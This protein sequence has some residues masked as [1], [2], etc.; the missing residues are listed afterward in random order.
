ML[1]Q[2]LVV[3]I[4]KYPG[5]QN[6]KTPAG[7]AEMIASL[8]Q[9]H[10]GFQVVKRL[11]VKDN[12]GL[13]SVDE[14]PS[15]QQLVTATTL[16]EAIA[17]LFN[18][19]GNDVPDTALLYFAGHGLRNNK[20]ITEGFLATSNAN[21]RKDVWGVSLN[22]LQRI[23]KS[24]PVKEQIIWL[25]CCYGGELL[26]GQ[27]LN[28]DEANPGEPGKGRDR[29]FIA[30]CGDTSVAYGNAEHGILTSL[31]LKGLDPQRY[32][33][34][35][36]INN[37]SLTDFIIQ[38]LE[39]D[40][41]LRTFPQ[42]PS[43]N[44][45]GG[46]IKLI[47]G[48]AKP[49]EE[50]TIGNTSKQ[51]LQ[52]LLHWLIRLLEDDAIESI[53][54][55]S[56]AIPGKNL[57]VAANNI[58]VFYKDGHSSFIQTQDTENWE[59]QNQIDLE[60]LVPNSKLAMLVLERYIQNNNHNTYLK[61]TKYKITRS[62]ILAELAKHELN[63]TPKRSEAEILANFN[64]AS[65]I[66]RYWLREIDGKKISRS[67][68]PQIIE[69][70]EQ[71]S[72]TILLIDR[73]GSGK[74]CMLLDL[75]DY[76]E[77]KK[78][79][80]W[81]LLFIKGDKFTNI[82]SEQKLT[83]HGLPE[84][85]V[86]QCAR[87][88]DYRKVVVII[89]SLDVLSL[90]RQHGSLKV[91]L[92]IIDRLEKLEKV[93]VIVA[94]RNFDLEYDPL[95]RGRS[96][97]H[98]INLQPLDFDTQVQSFLIDWQVDVSKMTLVLRS[99]LQIPQNLRIYERLA[100]LGVSSQPASAYELY[101]SFLEEVVVKNSILGT[102]AIDA[103]QNMA[104]Q[105]MQQR[106][107]SY[108]KVS[109]GASEDTVR[110]LISQEVLL[111]TSP[112]ILEFSHKTLADCL[113]VRATR[114]KNQTLVQFILQHP[115]LPFIRPAVRA[116]F[117]YLRAYQPDAFRRQVWEVLSHDEIAYHVK[118][119]VSESFAEIEPIEE[120][121]RSLRRIFQNYP[122]L[123]R[124]LLWRANN[125]TW[126]NI[127]TQHWLPEAKLAQ[128]RET[129]LLQFVH[130]LGA[131]MNKYPAE[132]VAFWRQAIAEQ[133]ANPQ[134][135]TGSIRSML[136]SFEAWDTPGIQELLET[137]VEDFEIEE[138]DRLGRL[139]SRW[140]Q[141]TNSGDILLWKYITKNVLPEDVGNWD[142]RNK[143]YC[144]PHEFHQ[145]NFLAERLKQS[146]L[147]LTLAL[148][149][150][151]GWRELLSLT[152]WGLQHSQGVIHSVDS[153]RFL[154]H[155]LE[156]ALKFR[157]RK[158]D[159]WW[160]TNE[161]RLRTLEID[162]IRYFVTQV[163]KENIEANIP[164]IENLL[165]DE[166]LFRWS[167][168]NYELGELMNMAYPYI[169]E[170][171]RV[172]NQTIIWSLCS[173]RKKYEEE[174]SC[175][176]YRR[177]YNFF[178]WIPCIFRT[179]ETQAFIDT[180]QNCFGYSRPEPNIHNWGG[181]VMPP[182]SSQD[183]LKLSNKG[184]FQLLDYY[185]AHKNRNIF[186]RDMIGGFSEVKVVLR[187]ACS[188]HPEKFIRLFISF[189]QENLYQD[190]VCALVE[191]IAFHL[192]YRFG[193]LQPAQQW[194]PIEPLLEGEAIASTLLNW[195]ER[196]FIIWEDGQTVRYALEACC[197]VLTDS[198]SAKRLSLL[199]FW[200]YNKYSEDRKIRINSHDLL[201]TAINSIHG[202]A[203]ESAIKLCNRLLEK[204]QPVP[205][206]LLLLLHHAA[207]DAA[208]YV[209]IPILQH[210]PFLIHKNPDL[211][212]QL[213]ADVFKEPQPHLWK[214]TELCFYYQYHHNFD[215][216]APYLNRLLYEGM[217]EAGDIWGRLSA[218]A[219]LA[220][221]ISQEQLFATLV[222]TNSNAAW[223][224]VTQV[225]IANLELK[226]HRENCITGLINVLGYKN[227]SQDILGK[228]DRC[229][230]EESKR[231]C[232]RREFAVAFLE[233]LPASAR[234]ID[235]DGFLEW[236]GYESRRNPLSALELT[237]TLA[238]KFESRMNV[239]LLWRTEPLI[240]ALNE[241]L[242]EA[243][244][245]D[246]PKLIQRAIN[247]QD[248]FLKLDMRGMEELLNKAGQD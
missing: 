155:S 231:A 17:E 142:F 3:G 186:D 208:I 36:W 165:Q 48:K 82:S 128:E 183:L 198:E 184:L 193:N 178:L 229:F 64:S 232:I 8:L 110:Q 61:D 195:L 12:E 242:R 226:E 19:Q 14:N 5:L 78:A 194:E 204:E 67:E 43:Y 114:A 86:G 6:L 161:P 9:K 121:W 15:P 235:F 189:I 236:L 219:S 149:E 53:Q 4:N 95:L 7:D 32:E 164:G 35:Q 29:C 138:H 140:V 117:F 203:A 30:A 99:L 169:S 127:I 230:E 180:W 233:A 159:T 81:G 141:S 113:T 104:E 76:I 245:T 27:F 101:N 79:S 44:N 39:N 90:S 179:P 18:P 201:T 126:W 177:F 220:G 21:P 205:D 248:R 115:Q 131:W 16:Q 56:T 54:V 153:L 218:L 83:A 145:E 109:F 132:I 72:R 118:R 52:I 191:G 31:L 150:M 45:S 217:E 156:T 129:W 92:G 185:K 174:F 42:R 75:A 133:W 166:E 170:S 241:I 26:N 139:L 237:E 176:A 28:F 244:E 175:W 2:A 1:R 71:G 74:T 40:E 22:W 112:G 46:E 225:F 106:T 93:T 151:E 134:N 209:R 216:V 143:L 102:E 70:I 62:D 96:W 124:R 213:L 84:D 152:S 25:D 73:P 246:D 224:G 105:L 190:Y 214:Y 68:L 111:E 130:W 171:A 238:A 89:D 24:S 51:Q 60:R 136:N 137:L 55:D 154:L 197:D 57:S 239:S 108:S 135:L 63:P 65:S 37:Y 49:Y 13:L 85:I 50:A 227:I 100:K 196:Y 222:K 122:D 11:P 98:K 120:D 59:H 172:A 162:F 206:L 202:V 125:G 146:D 199:L 103:L 119:L 147:L 91:F 157:S 210:L 182:L 168:I 192:R 187:D 207:R 148:N 123:F 34:S 77:Q 87:L 160:Q 167:R 41:K 116:F 173:E 181:C 200:L 158:N 221:N 38:Q 20:G 243:D 228:I 58:V 234:D 223:Q 88:A 69:L 97:Q 211:G 33:V 23:L 80:V 215:I 107:Q 10:G 240:A 163:Y 247:L 144:Q 47:Q 212:W 94:C 188:L 66:G